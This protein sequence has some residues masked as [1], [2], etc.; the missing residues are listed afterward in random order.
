MGC[1]LIC[2]LAKPKW[3]NLVRGIP[4]QALCR[5]CLTS[6]LVD[7]RGKF[8]IDINTFEFVMVL[9]LQA[10]EMVILIV[11]RQKVQRWYGTGSAGIFW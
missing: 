6:H 3:F 4:P 7:Y 10:E 9:V 2:L 1:G 5:L 11:A 8:I